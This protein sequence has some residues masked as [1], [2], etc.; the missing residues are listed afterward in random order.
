MSDSASPPPGQGFIP[1]REPPTALEWANLRAGALQLK[2]DGLAAVLSGELEPAEIGL[3]HLRPRS[4]RRPPA[5][6][7]PWAYGLSR[8][9]AAVYLGIGRSHFDALVKVGRLPQP[10]PGLGR[11]RVWS[12]AAL[13]AVLGGREVSEISET[14]QPRNPWDDVLPGRA[15]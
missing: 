5:E 1:P 12:R 13:D 6:P 7:Q 2:V 15:P 9:Q 11:R 4:R 8:A 10:L 3:P 14:W